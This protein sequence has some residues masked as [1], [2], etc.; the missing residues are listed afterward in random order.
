MLSNYI[1]VYKLISFKN[2]NIVAPATFVI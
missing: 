2:F 1:I